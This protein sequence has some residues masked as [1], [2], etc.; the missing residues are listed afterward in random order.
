MRTRPLLAAPLLAAALLAGCSGDGDDRAGAPAPAPSTAAGATGT[1]PAPDAPGAPAPARPSGT[2]PPGTPPAGGAPAGGATAPGG[3]PA[4]SPQGS[5]SPS[6]A[7]APPAEGTTSVEAGTAFVLADGSTGCVLSGSGAR[8]DTPVRSWEPPPG[9]CAQD[10][11]QGVEVRDGSVGFTCGG[12]SPLGA[13]RTLA[14]G[15]ALRVAEVVC[16]ALPE[17]VQC[18]D[19]ASGR[20]FV[21]SRAAYAFF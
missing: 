13:Q 20:G 21:V 2:A 10:Y 5:R 16:L 19:G 9:D 11:G 14:A 15:E 8:C 6:R 3:A 7:P 18:E 4:P 12:E 17:G 1:T